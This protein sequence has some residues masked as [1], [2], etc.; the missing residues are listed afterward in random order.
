ML[1]TLILP[2]AKTVEL[3][4]ITTEGQT[5]ILHLKTTAPQAVCPLCGQIAHRIHSR[6][7]RHSHDLPLTAIPV[8]R[9]LQV[10][11]LHC[12]NPVGP[13]RIFAEQLPDLIGA[14]AH[15]TNR[16]AERLCQVAFSSGGEGGSRLAK[17][18]GIPASP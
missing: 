14:N 16:Q 1:S 13:R 4:Q 5:I 9:R 17:Q 2:E 11:R 18:I 12:E 6:Y 8:K 10:R 7:I 15:R 3:E